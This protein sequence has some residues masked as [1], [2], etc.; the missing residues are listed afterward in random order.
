MSLYR[1]SVWISCFLNY[2]LWNPIISE[3]EYL[4][5]VF[6]SAGHMYTYIYKCM[7]TPGRTHKAYGNRNNYKSL[8]SF[9][10]F[11]IAWTL[12][13]LRKGGS[14]ITSLNTSV[15]KGQKIIPPHRIS[16]FIT[17]NDHHDRLC[18]C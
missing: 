15:K 2:L 8:I 17:R 11:L 7:D 16:V 14:F 13:V 3:Y 10:S 12:Q 18:V 9:G 5:Y 6:V 1:H 4:S